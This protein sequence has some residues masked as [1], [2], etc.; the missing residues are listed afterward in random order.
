MRVGGEARTS[1]ITYP[2]NGRVP[3]PKAG[4]ARAGM[5]NFT[6]SLK[7][8]VALEPCDLRMSFNGL[9]GLVRDQQLAFASQMEAR[10]VEVLWADPV[11]GATVQYYPV[12][13]YGGSDS[14]TYQVSDGVS[15][16]PAAAGSTPVK[17]MTMT[18]TLSTASPTMVEPM[19]GGFPRT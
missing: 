5:L 16:S 9:H 6:G 11:P 2:A 7:V 12:P 14:F 17:V 15:G 1:L 3:A 4:A 10:D 8:F 18:R 19:N 13:G